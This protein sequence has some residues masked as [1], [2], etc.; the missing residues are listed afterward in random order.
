MALHNV[1]VPAA[2]SGPADAE[3][4]HQLEPERWEWSLKACRRVALFTVAVL[5]LSVGV[6]VVW[7][8][9]LRIHLYPLMVSMTLSCANV[10][11][12]LCEMYFNPAAELPAVLVL[13]VLF[14]HAFE[15]L[16]VLV[17]SGPTVDPTNDGSDT[18]AYLFCSAFFAVLGAD[19]L[20]VLLRHTQQQR[21]LLEAM[22]RRAASWALEE[23]K[24]QKKEKRKLPPVERFCQASA[25][26]DSVTETLCCS[27]CL[28]D[29]T[30][31]QE[32]GRLACRHTFHASC[33]D[34]WLA[35]SLKSSPGCPFR[36]PLTAGA[37]AVDRSRPG[38]ATM[39]GAAAEEED[40]AR[41]P[42]TSFEV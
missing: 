5:D 42:M 39:L 21:H 27:I 29:L 8:A 24:A 32:L 20:L 4:V 37:A 23:S 19:L 26:A 1:T 41:Q 16:T 13:P 17:V 12:R 22:Q 18:S 31:G 34:R 30:P 33:L 15:Y 10:A 28:A 3:T 14:F 2:A 40:A 25:P 38:E 11:L 6:P 35:G 9:T 36:C 7:L